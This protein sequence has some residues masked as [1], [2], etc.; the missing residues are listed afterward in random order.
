MKVQKEAMEKSIKQK[1]LTLTSQRSAL[2]T[3][4]FEIY[5]VVSKVQGKVLDKELIQWKREQQ[6]SGNGY[7]M[8]QGYLETLQE[9]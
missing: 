7:N 5:E 9:W 4:F 8:N 2:T 6:L 1:Y 3:A